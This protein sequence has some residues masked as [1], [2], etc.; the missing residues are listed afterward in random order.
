MVWV[1]NPVHSSRSKA[2]L[3]GSDAVPRHI[4]ETSHSFTVRERQSPRLCFAS[5]L[6][7]NKKRYVSATAET[8]LGPRAPQEPRMQIYSVTQSCFSEAVTAHVSSE[9]T[10]FQVTSKCWMF[11]VYPQQHGKTE[12]IFKCIPEIPHIVLRDLISDSKL[13]KII[14]QIIINIFLNDLWTFI[15]FGNPQSYILRRKIINITKRF[16]KTK[17]SIISCVIFI[18]TFMFLIIIY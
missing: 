6:A 15:G 3:L 4:G 5:L 17:L 12:F 7:K 18:N 10:S 16:G 11:P 2:R 9:L 14:I 13:E 8:A 1:W